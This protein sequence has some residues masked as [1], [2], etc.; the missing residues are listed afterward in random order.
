MAGMDEERAENAL[1]FSARLREARTRIGY[2]HGDVAS[3]L[4][5]TREGYGD[6]KSVV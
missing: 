4:G 1:T 5:V 6:R 2:S 3:L